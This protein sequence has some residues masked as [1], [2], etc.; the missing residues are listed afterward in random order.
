MTP[1]D[2]KA[3]FNRLFNASHFLRVDPNHPLDLL[4]GVDKEGRK[5]LRFEGSFVPAKI[6]GTKAIVVKHFTLPQQRMCIQ[7]S[8]ADPDTADPFYKFIDDL[9]DSSRKFSVS[10]N[11]YTFV[12]QRFARWK[13]MFVPARDVLSESSIMGLL[14]E[15]YFLAS[16]MIP[17]YG[18]QRA[19]A[20]WGAAERTIKDFSIDNTWYEIKTAGS[21][22]QTV[23]INSVQQLDSPNP[24]FLVVV[25]LE[26][27]AESYSGKSLNPLVR[28]IMNRVVS[29]EVLEE[30]QD[31]LA[32]WGYA[33]NDKY[34]EYVYEVKDLT[35]YAVDKTF[36]MLKAKALGEA[37]PNAEY[38]LLL[39]KIK[40][41]AVD[42]NSEE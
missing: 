29:P 11:G 34:D 24:G 7:F 13:K 20:S 37:I 22:S 42:R 31:K 1:Y 25:R 9:V 3:Q 2:S 35:S 21:K 26:K 16:Y 39:E 10:E 8:L 14:G 32:K 28:E 18:E 23:H 17:R 41:F 33:Y 19:I 5:T 15:L 30:F 40:D 38:D 36:P 6:S 27:M 12:I 4:L